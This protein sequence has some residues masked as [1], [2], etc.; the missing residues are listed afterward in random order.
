MVTIFID[1]ALFHLISTGWPSITFVKDIGGYPKLSPALRWCDRI[2]HYNMNYFPWVCSAKN[3]FFL[4]WRL[5]HRKLWDSNNLLLWNFVILIF[6]R[7]TIYD[8]RMG[9]WFYDNKLKEMN[10]NWFIPMLTYYSLLTVDWAER[11]NWGNNI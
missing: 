3:F 8:N 2:T 5:R 11:K 9:Y 7:L 10:K 4:F 6:C 1:I